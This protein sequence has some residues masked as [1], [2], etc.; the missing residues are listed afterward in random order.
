MFKI[1]SKKEMWEEGYE[2]YLISI[3]WL[4]SSIVT[5][6][7][8]TISL[9]FKNLKPLI[10]LGLIFIHPWRFHPSEMEIILKS[11]YVKIFGIICF[12]PFIIY[13]LLKIYLKMI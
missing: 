6:L 12:L 8:L 4:I 3:F 5:I 1:F 2:D 10:L 11:K 9:I 13:V 7:L